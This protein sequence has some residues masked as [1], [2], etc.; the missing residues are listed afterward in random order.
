M[1]VVHNRYQINVCFDRVCA[2]FIEEG[3][4]REGE[5]EGWWEGERGV[6]GVVHNRYLYQINI[7]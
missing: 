4:R 3:G 1:V 7:K 2:S 5:G 6:L